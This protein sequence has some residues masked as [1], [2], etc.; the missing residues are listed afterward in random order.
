MLMRRVVPGFIVAFAMALFLKL[1]PSPET[2]HPDLYRTYRAMR[3]LC[4]EG[5]LSQSSF[6]YFYP[7]CRPSEWVSFAFSTFG[8]AEWAPREGVE[9]SPEEARIARITSMPRDVSVV[10]LRARRNFGKQLVLAFDDDKGIVTADAY[11]AWNEKPV[12]H[13]EWSVPVVTPSEFAVEI[14]ESNLQMGASYETDL[15]LW[16]SDMDEFGVWE[17]SAP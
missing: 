16:G 1:Y 12:F 5:N 13:R 14:A 7:D 11:A 4:T 8:T 15:E 3:N 6:A 2:D 10:P 9:L 17:D